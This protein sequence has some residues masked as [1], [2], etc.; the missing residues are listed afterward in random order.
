MIN[1]VKGTYD[2]LFDETKKWQKLEEII[3]KIFSLYNY[4]EIRTPILEYKQVFHRETENSDMV[5]KETYNF[6]DKAGREITLRPEGTAGVI[7]SYIENKLYINNELQKLYYLGPNFRYERPQKGRY[8]QFS[9][10]G[11]E[12]IGIDNVYIDLEVIALASQILKTLGLKDI[13]VNLNSLGD[14]ESSTAY[15]K[16][17]HEYFK[18]SQTLLCD[19]CKS[20]IKTNPLRILDC[21]IDGNHQLVKDAPLPLD[22]LNLASKTRFEN[23][24]KALNNSKISYQI[25]PRLVRGLDYYCHTVFEI[26]AQI[27]GFG[28]QNVLCGGGRY[29]NLVKELGGPDK[30]GIGFAFGIERLLMALEANQVELISLEQTDCYILYFNESDILAAT[31]LLNT[32]RVNEINAEINYDSKNF[33]TQLKNAL[34]KNARYL[35]ILG[36]DELKNETITIKDTNLETQETIKQTEL[37]LYLKKRLK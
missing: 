14:K 26:E 6:L 20:R 10:F 17:L 12:A 1:K 11:V 29:S 35:L 9:Q 31:T 28:S 27:E 5:K 4:Y 15:K 7:R 22:S 25:N 13:R 33:K 23:L 8:R 16:V 30:S 34:G 3:R 37:I 32:L 21:K 2:L 36:E 18:D 19:D 24:L